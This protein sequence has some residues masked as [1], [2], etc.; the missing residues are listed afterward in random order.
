M[1][2]AR[3]R[4]DTICAYPCVTANDVKRAMWS[5]ST[6]AHQN[7]QDAPD[8]WRDTL[9]SSFPEVDVEGRGGFECQMRV[10]RSFATQFTM[11]QG[12]PHLVRTRAGMRGRRASISLAFNLSGE[13]EIIQNGLIVRMRDREATFIDLGRPYEIR[14]NSDFRIMTVTVA[15]QALDG[16][17]RRAGALIGRKFG[18][19]GS[20]FPIHMEYIR[21]ITLDGDR[22]AAGDLR[23]CENAALD[24]IRDLIV[25]NTGT[26]SA[27]NDAM[28][29]IA[30][31]D[32]YID[33]NVTASDLDRFSVARATGYSVRELNRTLGVVGSSVSR[34]IKEKRLLRAAQLL[35]DKTWNWMSITDVA[36]ECGFVQ[37]STFS[38]EFSNRHG[39]PPRRFRELSRSPAAVATSRSPWEGDL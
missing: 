35:Q 27:S 18:F 20:A 31:I 15:E 23:I 1:G 26:R 11:G 21:L 8:R 6:G 30:A 36:F 16:L 2:H 29:K 24:L 32:R 34:R 7:R 39:L 38:R 5:E 22:V 14:H 28:R 3:V 12:T 33:E 4:T 17:Y 13:T 10:Q 9:A 25:S 37:S 19:E